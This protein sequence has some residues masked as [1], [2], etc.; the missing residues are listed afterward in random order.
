MSNKDTNSL[1]ISLSQCQDLWWE[2]V[3]LGATASMF[4][5]DREN[6]S[7]FH[8]STKITR[9]MPQRSGSISEHVSL[10]ARRFANPAVPA[11]S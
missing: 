11:A 9:R 5:N 4:S 7:F 10:S 8:F 6:G 3:P 1:S 2:L